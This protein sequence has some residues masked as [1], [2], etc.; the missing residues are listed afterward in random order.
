MKILC[1]GNPEKFSIAKAVKNKWADSCC[2]SLSS[3]L[4]LRLIDQLDRDRFKK[5]VVDHNVFVNSSFIGPGI[6]AKL[7]DLVCDT[8]MEADIKGHIIT[9]G[10]TLE[11]SEDHKYREYVQ[12]KQQLRQASLDLNA[13]S[14]ITGVKT[15]YLILGGVND[16]QPQNLG[17]VH[18]DSIVDTIEWVL[19]CPDRLALIQLE[20]N[21]IT[22]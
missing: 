20:K 4:D 8:W 14:G 10:T 2:V 6:Q 17:F 21:K 22:N 5:L 16:Q 9:I 19:N 13:Q 11:W 1:T 7:L 12:T 18:P 3:G 15:T